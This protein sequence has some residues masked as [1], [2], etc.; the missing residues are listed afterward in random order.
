MLPRAHAPEVGEEVAPRGEGQRRYPR[1]AVDAAGA[2]PRRRLEPQRRRVGVRVGVGAALQQHGDDLGHVGAGGLQE[3]VQNPV[4]APVKARAVGALGDE[5]GMHRHVGVAA[6]RKS[7]D[8][9]GLRLDVY[10]HHV[11]LKRV[12]DALLAQHRRLHGVEHILVRRPHHLRYPRAR[13]DK[14]AETYRLEP[15]A[16]VGVSPLIFAGGHGGGRRLLCRLWRGP[17]DDGRLVDASPQL[18][19]LLLGS[20]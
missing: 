3:R 12:L 17:A 18:F 6:L 16:G 14:A 1:G 7:D 2:L 11:H 15:W 9:Q 13:V 19:H 8:G 4:A 5:P 10:G 20:A